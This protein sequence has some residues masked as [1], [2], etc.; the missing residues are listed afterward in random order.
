MKK[1]KIIMVLG[2]LSVFS[3]SGCGQ[4]ENENSQKQKAT[5]EKETVLSSPTLP[6]R[7]QKNRNKA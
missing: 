1:G 5:E 3:F 2:I 6:L 7:S 4:Q